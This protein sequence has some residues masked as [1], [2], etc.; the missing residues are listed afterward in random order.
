MNGGLMPEDFKTLINRL[1]EHAV[2]HFELLKNAL[3]RE[4]Y[5]TADFTAQV[6]VLTLTKLRALIN[7]NLRYFRKEE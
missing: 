6:V 5:D 3:E 2:K 7:S 1:F 4:E